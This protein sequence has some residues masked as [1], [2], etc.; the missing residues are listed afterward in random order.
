MQSL[1]LPIKNETVD[2]RI[3]QEEVTITASMVGQDMTRKRK[4]GVEDSTELTGSPPARRIA[5]DSIIR[6]SEKV[7]VSTQDGSF[8]TTAS[9]TAEDELGKRSLDAEDAPEL[10][11]RPPFQ[12]KNIEFKSPHS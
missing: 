3:K 2:V 6:T 10:A 12:K 4:S 5:L 11:R 8:A 1:Y 7:A 9:N